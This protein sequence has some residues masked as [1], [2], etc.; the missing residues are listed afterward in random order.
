MGEIKSKAERRFQLFWN[1]FFIVISIV[2]LIPIIR[3]FS[4]S[5]SSK[6]AILA[7]RVFLYPV[8]ATTEAYIRSFQSGSFVSS[9]IFSVFLMIGSTNSSSLAL[10]SVAVRC[11][12]P[13]AV[14]VM[15]GRLISLLRVVDNSILAFSAASLSLCTA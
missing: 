10:V 8:Q 6:D 7:G 14:A 9:F 15:N 3:V 12:G 11:L 4:M 5:L 1:T 13:S 2:A